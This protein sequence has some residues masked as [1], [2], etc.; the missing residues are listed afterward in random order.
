MED[1]VKIEAGH[2]QQQPAIFCRGQ[3]VNKNNG[4]KKR[5]KSKGVE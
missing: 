4:C 1:R 2:N 3:V 5:Q